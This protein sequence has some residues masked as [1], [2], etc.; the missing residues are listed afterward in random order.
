MISQSAFIPSWPAGIQLIKGWGLHE[1]VRLTITWQ[2]YKSNLSVRLPLL[3]FSFLIDKDVIQPNQ[4]LQLYLLARVRLQSDT[5]Q[6]FSFLFMIDKS[7]SEIKQKLCNLYLAKVQLKSVSEVA[8]SQLFLF[9]ID[10]SESEIKNKLRNFKYYTLSTIYLGK[11]QLKY[12]SEVASSQLF[13]FW[14]TK[15]KVKS[16]KNFATSSIILLVQYT[17]QKYGCEWG[18][19]FSTSALYFWS[20][21]VK[22]KSSKNSLTYTWQKYGS[23][24]SISPHGLISAPPASVTLATVASAP[25]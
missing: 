1:R 10:E 17:W 24:L 14:L 8:S 22:V 7:E 20:T 18:C 13:Y 19:H 3:N 25:Q 16:S 11:V 12:M 5:S 21:K 9:L 2:E 23:S 15:V 6:S 4:K